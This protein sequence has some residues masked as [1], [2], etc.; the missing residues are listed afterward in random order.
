MKGIS[1]KASLR[2]LS[3]LDEQGSAD[4]TPFADGTTDRVLLKAENQRSLLSNEQ[5]L[6]ALHKAALI[7]V[8][9]GGCALLDAGR[10]HL[11]RA[12]AA[13]DPDSDNAFGDQHRNI[14]RTTV[15]KDGLLSEARVNLNES[16]L[17]RL[18]VL[19][20]KTGQ[21][22]LSDAAFAAGERLRNDFNQGQLMQKVTSSWDAAR[23]SK[24]QKGG[25]GGM[26]DLSDSAIDARSRFHKA[27]DRLGPDLAGAI[28][29][30]C[31][32]L[33]GLQAVERDRSWPPRSAKLMVQVGLDL[34]ARHYGLDVRGTT[35][36]RVRKWGA[37]NY[38]PTISGHL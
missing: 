38:R 3:F 22:W 35:V 8:G 21:P 33:K 1:Q 20:T 29:D 15:R 18:R 34:L 2:L 10:K 5:T 13:L 31:C 4:I 26:A 17:M 36:K 23:G 11:K 30:V 24:G 19:K 9:D 37:D 14:K 6:D 32:F 12:Q 7:S 27:V 25:A 16:P 28:T